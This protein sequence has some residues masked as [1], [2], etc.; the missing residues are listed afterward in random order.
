[1]L[2]KGRKS[3]SQTGIHGENS[4]VYVQKEKRSDTNMA[5]EHQKR[6]LAALMAASIAIPTP[7]LAASV[8]AFW[9]LE[10]V[11]LA[12]LGSFVFAFC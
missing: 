10:G 3:F 8:S 6:V 9:G 11:I 5:K 12:D 4:I 2:T 7:V 1:M